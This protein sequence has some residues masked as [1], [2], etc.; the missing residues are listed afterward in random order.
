MGDKMELKGLNTVM[1]R[2]RME[3]RIYCEIP[4]WR[5]EK[6]NLLIKLHLMVA[7]TSYSGG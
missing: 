4:R 2:S 6:V 5:A 7:A 3:G 1:L